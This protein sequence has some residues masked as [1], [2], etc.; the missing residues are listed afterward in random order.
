[1]RYMGS[2]RRIA[3]HILPIMIDAADK[4]VETLFRVL[5]D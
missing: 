1:M 3:K 4:A 5:P 2:K